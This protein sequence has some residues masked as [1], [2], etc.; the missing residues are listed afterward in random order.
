MWGF[1]PLAADTQSPALS[2]SPTLLS[3]FIR[4]QEGGGGF[5]IIKTKQSWILTSR[6]DSGQRTQGEPPVCCWSAPP[7]WSPRRKEEAAQEVRKGAAQEVV[8]GKQMHPRS[9]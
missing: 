6:H 8:N 1:F 3:H 4:K 7:R 2:N 9:L 5:S